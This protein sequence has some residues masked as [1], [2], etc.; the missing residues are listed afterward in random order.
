MAKK[1]KN[2]TKDWVVILAFVAVFV[3]L[4][5]ATVYYLFNQGELGKRSNLIGDGVCGNVPSEEG[6]D[7]CCEKAHEDDI[8]IECKGSW[9]YVSGMEVCQY[10]CGGTEPACL[11][12][13]RVCPDGVTSVVRNAANDC[14][15]DPC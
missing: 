7:F 1:R 14:E 2:K 3:F 15:F 13:S 11:E 5:S 10:V 8:H 4:I 12:D 9:E 6:Q